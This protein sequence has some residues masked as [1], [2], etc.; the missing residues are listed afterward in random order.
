MSLYICMTQ[1]IT[2][3]LGISVGSFLNVVIHRL[4]R[5]QSVISPG[6]HCPE[7]GSVIRVVD[8]VPLLS[9]VILLGL[10]RD[11]GAVISSRYFLVE[12]LTGALT[13]AVIAK[14]GVT[15]Q[16]LLYCFLVWTLI[17]VSFID[18]E[19]QII[20]DELS[21]GAAISGLAVSFMTPIGFDGALAGFLLGGGVFFILAIA[22]PG[23][24]GG[25]DIKLMAAIG[26]F[27]GWKLV[28][29]TI[30]IGSAVGSVAGLSSMALF[31]KTRKDR[32][33]FGPFLAL[34]AI[35]SVLWG[36]WVIAVY[37][38]TIV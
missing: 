38:D 5:N 11:C 15:T 1:A 29:L 31:G 3:A 10:C 18:L 28:L 22:Y 23:G 33:P 25:G 7:C 9:W 19:H 34:G 37:L 16:G 27:I 2:F 32:I 8:N 21:V 12:L 14:Y 24:M 4:P 35:I 20:P 17:S 6:S 26:A 13:V 36:D 30:L